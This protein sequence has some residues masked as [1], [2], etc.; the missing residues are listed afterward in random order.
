MT[1]M[2]IT[3]RI[4][5]RT[6]VTVMTMLR[7]TMA[8]TGVCKINGAFVVDCC[9]KTNGRTTVNNNDNTVYFANTGM[10]IMKLTVIL[11]I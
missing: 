10:T 2:T 4:M 6:T 8:S 7:R 11:M 9:W 5:T 3:I 1:T